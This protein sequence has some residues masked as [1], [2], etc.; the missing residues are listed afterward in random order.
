MMKRGERMLKKNCILIL[1]IVYFS[2][3][4]KRVKSMV[5]LSQN[6]V[7]GISSPPLALLKKEYTEKVPFSLLKTILTFLLKPRCPAFVKK[8]TTYFIET[9]LQ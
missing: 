2:N 6:D 8:K 3:L 7:Y 1:R 9:D 4:R 5:S